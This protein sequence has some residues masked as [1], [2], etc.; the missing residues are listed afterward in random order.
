MSATFKSASH[1]SLEDYMKHFALSHSTLC[2]NNAHF[3]GKFIIIF[4]EYNKGNRNEIYL[5]Q[6]QILHDDDGT[7]FH[8]SESVVNSFILT[9]TDTLKPELPTAEKLS[10]TFEPALLSYSFLRLHAYSCSISTKT[11]W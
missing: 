5:K 3:S 10:R 11:R 2:C 1:S 4:S 9:L 7:V 8:S 6:T